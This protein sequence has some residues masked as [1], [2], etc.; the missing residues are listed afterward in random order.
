MRS[1]DR[2]IERIGKKG[3]VRT[4]IPSSRGER[5][6]PTAESNMGTEVDE[7]SVKA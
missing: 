3:E 1:G 7:M 6:V 2:C 5:V 4:E